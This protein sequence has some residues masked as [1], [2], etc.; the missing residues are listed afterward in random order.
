MKEFALAEW[1][2]AHRAFRSVKYLMDIDPDSA[3]SRAYYSAFHAVTAL[4][5]LRGMTFSKHAALRAA[6]HRDLIKTKEWSADLG[7]GFDFL[8]ELRETGDYGGLIA[9]SK[10]DVEK[11]LKK[12]SAILDAVHKS[13]PELPKKITE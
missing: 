4:L 9:V 7:R 11:A 5:A 3:A 6:I 2:R 1:Q 8:L 13:C 12:T 10:E